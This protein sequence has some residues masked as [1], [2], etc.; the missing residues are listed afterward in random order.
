MARVGFLLANIKIMLTKHEVLK[1]LKRLGVKES[2]LLE[3]YLK[4]F[5]RYLEFN[6]GLKLIE[7]KRPKRIPKTR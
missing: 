2:L 7:W 5:E 4:D 6:H 3:F 1:E